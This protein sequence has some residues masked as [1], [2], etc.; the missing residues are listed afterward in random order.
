MAQCPPPP[1]KYSPAVKREKRSVCPQMSYKKMK[2]LRLNSQLCFC[3]R[4]RAA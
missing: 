1:L 2:G 3:K 4:R